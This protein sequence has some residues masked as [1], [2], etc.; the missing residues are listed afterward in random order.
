[1]WWGRTSWLYFDVRADN[2]PDV[3]TAQRRGKPARHES[4]HDLDVLEVARGVLHEREPSG[5]KCVGDEK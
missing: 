2:G 1:M 3:F 5:A 4:V